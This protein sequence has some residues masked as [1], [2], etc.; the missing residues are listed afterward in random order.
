[1][2]PSRLTGDLAQL[3]DSPKTSIPMCWSDPAQIE[4]FKNHLLDYKVA[5]SQGRH[6]TQA[7]V[8]QKKFFERWPAEL[9]LWPDL[10]QDRTLTTEEGNKLSAYIDETNKVGC[11][12]VVRGW[13]LIVSV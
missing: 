6:S 4:F 7:T 13:W 8:I 12:A 2:L 3:V 9:T 1:M 5:I 10:P 11:F